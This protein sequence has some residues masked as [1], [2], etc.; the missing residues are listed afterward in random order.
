[1]APLVPRLSAQARL[2]LALLVRPHG[3]GVGGGDVATGHDGFITPQIPAST[4]AERL[5]L[6]DKEVVEAVNRI[7]RFMIFK[8]LLA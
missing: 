8:A 4:I 3:R 6:L 1:M 7:I 2:E 5:G